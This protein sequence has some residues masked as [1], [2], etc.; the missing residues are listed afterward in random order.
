MVDFTR[1]H[2]SYLTGTETSGS[3]VALTIIGKYYKWITT[4]YPVAN[5]IE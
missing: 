1:V 3:E 5:L 4:N 2:Q